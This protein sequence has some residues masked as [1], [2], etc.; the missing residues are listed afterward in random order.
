[1]LSATNSAVPWLAVVSM[2]TS[3]QH[4]KILLLAAT[5]LALGVLWTYLF[6]KQ[7]IGLN[8]S[9]FMLMVAAGGVLLSRVFARPLGAGVYTLIGASIFFSSMVFVRSSELLTLFNMLGSLLIF[10]LVGSV[11]AG[12]RLRS[13]L[14]LD[15]VKVF[16]LPLR[17]L[18]TFW[19]TFSEIISL[20]RIA[21]EGT[22]AREIL[23]GSLMAAVALAAFG[24]LFAS[25]D[26]G[27]AN[28]FSKIFSF[29]IDQDFLNTAFLTVL[30]GAFFIGTF[31]FIFNTLHADAETRP[32]GGK[33]RLGALETTILLGSINALFLVFI[34]LQ[35]SYLFGGAAHL[36]D[37]GLTYADYARE[38]FFQL[39]A[40]AMLS[41]LVIAFA[42]R[43]VIRRDEGHFHSFKL[44][45]GALVVQVILI[46][47]SAF[48]RLSLYEQTY[49]FTTI[50]LYSHAFMIWIGF[51]LL[52]LSIH[53]WKNGRQQSLAFQI[54]CTVVLFFF[55][56]NALNPDVFI[57]KKNIA[58]YHETG[59]VDI[60]YLS[61]LSDDALPYTVAL[62]DDPN[63]EVRKGFAHALYSRECG[64]AGCS[65]TRARS[66]KSERFPYLTAERL[67]AS[68][69]AMLEENKDWP[70]TT[71]SST[72][73]DNR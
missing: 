68:R 45:S 71:S 56:M 58:R 10:L 5:S 65:E 48:S 55:A 70:T 4:A 12:K 16:F 47:F 38:G 25:A 22:R 32:E 69:R 23:R 7:N 19:T 40:V 50:R 28:L 35:I 11:L 3:S 42:E 8:F 60:D 30:V 21:R 37:Q 46:L 18:A 54:F 43:Q 26:T 14:P 6:Y 34:L 29:S 9:I 36:V 31:G 15:Y 41:F 1:M 52:L 49:G 64:K 2:N 53:I 39:I 67:I 66:W 13:F 72:V 57:A 33:R 27:F 62:L 61:R 63:D 73:P 44:L 17:F 20:N 59:K 24:L 51:A